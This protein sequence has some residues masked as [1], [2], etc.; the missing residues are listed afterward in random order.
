MSQQQGFGISIYPICDLMNLEQCD[1]IATLVLLPHSLVFA[2]QSD[3]R[4][5]CVAFACSSL[6]WED[7]KKCPEV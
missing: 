1:V 4:L 5:T 3:C 2:F 6:D 7:W